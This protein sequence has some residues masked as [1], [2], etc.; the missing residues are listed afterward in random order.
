MFGTR[1]VSFVSILA[2]LL[3]ACAAPTARAEV[4]VVP[5]SLAT[6]DG[7]IFNDSPMFPLRYMQIHDASQFAALSA[8]VF[9]TQFAWRPDTLPGPTGPYMHDVQLFAS[10]TNRSVAG[11]SSTFAEN[12]GPDNTLVYSG[13]LTL[14]TANLPGPGNTKQ[15][16]I[17]VPF[18]TPFRYD[19]LAGNLLWDLHV[20]STSGQVIRRDTVSGN[21]VVNNLLAFSPTATSGTVGGAGAVLQFTYQPVPE[22]SG[23]AL[24]SLG[25]LGL[26]GSF[27]SRH[28]H[29]HL[30]QR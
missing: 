2:V 25:A 23:F 27:R 3:G 1:S 21:P 24:V 17:V 19:P 20:T 26:L 28:R 5:N 29:R 7:N 10:T 9:I 12:I 4:V 14:T 18:T 11:L 8:P 16:D 13:P 30:T 15:F 6:T 22:P